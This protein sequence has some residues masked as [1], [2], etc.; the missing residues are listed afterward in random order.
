MLRYRNI[1]GA[2]KYLEPLSEEEIAEIAF[3]HSDH[4]NIGLRSARLLSLYTPI[5]AL[6]GSLEPYSDLS[7][8]F[9]RFTGFYLFWF[10]FI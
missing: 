7:G 4:V 10:L 5:E 6:L 2:L 3:Q 9:V 8:G 1:S